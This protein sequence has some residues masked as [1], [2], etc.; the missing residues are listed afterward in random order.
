MKIVDG[1]AVRNVAGKCVAI[2]VSGKA[3]ALGGMIAL[4]E[5]GKLQAAALTKEFANKPLDV[6][7]TSPLLRAMMTAEGV[8]VELDERN[9]KIGKKIR[10][11]QLE[12]VPYML[13][14]GD[15][16]VEEGTVS[17]RSRKEGDLGAMSKEDFMAHILEKIAEKVG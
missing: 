4:N 11:A 13:I 8:R 2:A 1:F 12:K 3:T 16:E 14:V 10:E 9:E 5:T 7:Y 6:I 17:V 15:K